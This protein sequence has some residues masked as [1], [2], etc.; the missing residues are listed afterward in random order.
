MW[1]APPA[2]CTVLAGLFDSPSH[3]PLHDSGCT[4]PRWYSLSW[5]T[6]I[7]SVTLVALGPVMEMF[8]V[9]VLGVRQRHGEV[10]RALGEQRVGHRDRVVLTAEI[11]GPEGSAVARAGARHGVARLAEQRIAGVG[12]RPRAGRVARSAHAPAT[13]SRCRARTPRIQPSAHDLRQRHRRVVI[14]PFEQSYAVLPMHVMPG[15][16]QPPA[17]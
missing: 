5:P 6:G 12:H 10:E 15:G 9:L 8:A 14:V 7:V 2:T 4:Q 17:S 11:A 3:V 1:Y 13:R 16:E